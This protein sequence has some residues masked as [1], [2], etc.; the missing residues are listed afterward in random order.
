GSRAMATGVG[1]TRDAGVTDGTMTAERPKET[2]AAASRG[3]I[4][5][6]RTHSA[7]P[8]AHAA[9]RSRRASRMAVARRG[10]AKVEHHELELGR[11]DGR[12]FILRSACPIERARFDLHEDPRAR[13]VFDRVENGR[14]AALQDDVDR[15]G[16]ER[17]G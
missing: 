10:S 15:G 16:L 5:P 13:E 6:A 8:A 17:I 1:S 2:T 7:Q 4:A 14:V 3:A 12:A 9:A 11:E